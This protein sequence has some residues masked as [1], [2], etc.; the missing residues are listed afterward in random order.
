MNE[1]GEIKMIIGLLAIIKTAIIMLKCA[2]TL[3]A[4]VAV[5]FSIGF[6]LYI[7][8]N[9]KVNIVKPILKKVYSF[10]FL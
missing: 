5:Y 4:L 3:I 6:S 8:T 7:L 9:K 10:M 2:F 1:K